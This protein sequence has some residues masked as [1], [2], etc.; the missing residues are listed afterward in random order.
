MWLGL[1]NVYR[2]EITPTCLRDSE[3]KTRCARARELAWSAWNSAK[4]VQALGNHAWVGQNQNVPSLGLNVKYSLFVN[5]IWILTNLKEATS[6]KQRMLKKSFLLWCLPSWMY[7]PQIHRGSLAGGE[8]VSARKERLAS[9]YL[10]LRWVLLING[11]VRLY[12]DPEW[13]KSSTL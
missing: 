12:L 6:N 10:A 11:Q 7:F 2:R 4:I 5:P 1:P 9:V 3:P 8:H 13:Y